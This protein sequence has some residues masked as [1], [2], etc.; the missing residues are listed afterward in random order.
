MGSNLT[1][2]DM[3]QAL[4]LRLEIIDSAC[5]QTG[6]LEPAVAEILSLRILLFYFLINK[7]LKIFSSDPDQGQDRGHHHRGR[8]PRED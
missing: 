1:W 8:H 5:K 4:M 6:F 2:S 7:T 3:M